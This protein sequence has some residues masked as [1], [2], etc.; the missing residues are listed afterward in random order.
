[1]FAHADQI[2]RWSHGLSS[3]TP[4]MKNNALRSAR[5]NTSRGSRATSLNQCLAHAILMDATRTP[6]ILGSPHSFLLSLAALW[7]L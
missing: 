2:C 4:G 6:P 7:Q 3:A 1:M 5:I